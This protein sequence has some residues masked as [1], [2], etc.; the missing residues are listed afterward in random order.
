MIKHEFRVEVSSGRKGCGCGLG[1]VQ[2]EAS[3][4]MLI[5]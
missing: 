1:G 3:I 4:V 2:G 5:F